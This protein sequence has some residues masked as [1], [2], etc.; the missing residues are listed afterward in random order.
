MRFP[1][2]E[3]VSIGNRVRVN[4]AL[5]TERG[6]IG[7]VHS[8]PDSLGSPTFS[9]R[10]YGFSPHAPGEFGSES[11]YFL[12]RSPEF[13]EFYTEMLCLHLDE[14]NILALKQFKRNR[15]LSFI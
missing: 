15:E 1:G 8:Y 14:A 7:P 12:I 9:F 4:A 2:H 10:I 3:T 13:R 5:G 6:L 11:A